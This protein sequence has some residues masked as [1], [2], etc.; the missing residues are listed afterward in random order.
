[1]DLTEDQRRGLGVALNEAT[2]LGV[3][4]DPVRRRAGITLQVLTLPAEEG[5]A[6]PEDSRVQMLLHP[7]GRVAASLRAGAWDDAKAPVE[8]FALDQLLRVVQSFGGAPIYGWEFI[9]RTDDKF[10]QWSDR[11]SLDVRSGVD[12][13]SHTLDLFQEG[14]KRHLDLRIWFDE[15]TLRSPRGDT[16]PLDEFIAGGTRWWDGLFSNDP[17]TQGHGIGPIKP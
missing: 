9:D 4:V 6:P 5:A 13:M 12:G 14:N 16:I 11:L 15:L 2:L 10:T 17:R 3:E 8:R 7:V 1:M